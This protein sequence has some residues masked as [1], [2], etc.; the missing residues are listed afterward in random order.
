MWSLLFNGIM[1]ILY[2]IILSICEMATSENVRQ[3]W[4]ENVYFGS[5]QDVKEICQ[6]I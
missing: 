5:K 2:Y 3:L 6:I 4:L 1:I